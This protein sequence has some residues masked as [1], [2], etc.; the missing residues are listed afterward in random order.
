M[1]RVS[2]YGAV[3]DGETLCTAAVQKAVDD[4][5]ANGGGV[6]LF[7]GGRYALKA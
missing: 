6:V 2:E 4:C 5:S 7:E 1:Y 3:A